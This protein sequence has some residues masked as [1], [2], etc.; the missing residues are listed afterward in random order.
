MKANQIIASLFVLILLPLAIIIV[1]FS[2]FF[3]GK[4]VIFKQTRLG[5]NKKSF[6]IIKLRTMTNGKI[7]SFGKIIRNLG[8][9]EIP[10]LINIIRGEMNFIGPRPLTLND[11]ER[12]GW[13][14][15]NHFKRWSVKPGITGLAQLSPVCNKKLS[16]LKDSFYIDN[17][18]FRLNLSILIQ[19]ILVP[20]LGKKKLSNLNRK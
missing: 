13:N 10:Q 6:S 18:N 15:K 3:Q 17:N 14:D 9:D 12:L 7:T 8:L 20:F 5:K 11:V 2:Y 19:S 16:W 1:V 4:Q